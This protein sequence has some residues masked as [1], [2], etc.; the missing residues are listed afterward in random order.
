M[1]LSLLALLGP[2]AAGWYCTVGADVRPSCEKSQC[3]FLCMERI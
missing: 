2:A 3:C 1:T